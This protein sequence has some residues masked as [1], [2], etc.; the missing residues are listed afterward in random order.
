[1]LFRKSMSN[2][3]PVAEMQIPGN[4]WL[5]RRNIVSREEPVDPEKP[6][7][8]MQ[9]VWECEEAIMSDSDHAAWTLAQS[10]ELRR[11]AEVIDAYTLKLID[12]EK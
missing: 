2:V 4:R 11:E 10:I 8:K 12:E 6:E 7:G 5:V 1:M 3:Q 9:T